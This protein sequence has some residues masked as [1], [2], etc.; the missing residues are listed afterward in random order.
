MIRFSYHPELRTPTLVLA[1]LEKIVLAIGVLTSSLRR[2]PTV[3]VVALSDACLSF[4]LVV[5]RVATRAP[6]PHRTAH[7][8]IC[9]IDVEPRAGLV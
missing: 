7:A 3:F 2:R 1:S 8:V 5:R 9:G 4:V 6:M